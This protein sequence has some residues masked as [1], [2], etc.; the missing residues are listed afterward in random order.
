MI[1][2]RIP[3]DIRT[4]KEKI[5]FGLNVRQIVSS[6][7]ALGICVPLYIFG[8][9][10]IPDD[11]LSWLI[12]IIAVPLVSI[13]FVKV[14]GLPA[15]KFALVFLK[16]ELLFPKVRKFTTSVAY[17]VWQNE[18]VKES[19]PKSNRERKKE[20]K[21]RKNAS[22][23]RAVLISEAEKN[24]FNNFDVDN[25]KL[26][27]VNSEPSGSNGNGKKPKKDTEKT[28]APKKKSSLQKKAE[29]IEVKMSQHCDY[30]PSPKEQ[31]VLKKWRKI[32]HSNRVA[33]MNSKKKAVGNKSTKISHRRRAKSLIP[34]ST[35]DTIPYI[36]DYDEGLFE[37]QP[38]KYS[39]MFKISDVNYSTAKDED[40]VLFFVKLGEFYN[41]F[42]D[43]THVQLVIDNRL[44]SREEQENKIFYQPRGDS[45][46]NHRAEYNKILK[47]Q[48]VA[49]KN[50]MAII[51]F[52][53][54][55]IDADTAIEAILRFHKIQ[56]EVIDGLK[57][58]G[59]TATLMTTEERLSYYHDKFRKGR[60]GDFSID[61]DSVIKRGMS[62]KDYIAPSF[63]N[64]D[65]KHFIVEDDYYR[66]LYLTNLPASLAD[67]FLYELY[68]NDFPVTVSLSIQPVAQDKAL[69]MVNRKLTGIKHNK[70]EAEKR[71]SRAGYSQESIQHSIKDA[72]V[73][74]E[75]LLEDML[76]NNQK[77]FFVTITLMV[78]GNTLEELNDNT[79]ILESKARQRTVQLNVL[80]TQQEEG[81]K[82]TLPFGYAPVDVK[83]DCA[84]TTESTAI[85]MPFSAQE[86]FQ[87]G[88]YYY[89]LNQISRNLVI[90]DRTAM[91]TPSGFVLGS[92]GSGKSFATKR[93]ILNIL[94]NSAD[95]GV[96]VIDPENEYGDFGRAFNGTVI[97]LSAN[98][99][100]KINPMD[101]SEDYGLD[102]D[103]DPDNTPIATK[104]DKALSKKS[105]YILSL[106]ESMM[107]RGDTGDSATSITPQQMTIADRCV[108]KCYAKY[109]AIGEYS[110]A[111]QAEKNLPP[112]VPFDKNNIPTFVD[113][114]DELDKEKPG[115]EDARLLA[116]GIEFYTRGNMD[117]FAHK[118]NVDI[119]NRLV[120][121]NVRELG[122]K[123]QQV[124]LTIMFD[125][126]WNRMV[127][128]KNRGVRTYAYCDE[129][130]VMFKS[131][132]SAE[133]L[134]QLYK[135]GRK[136]G[137][138]VTGL[139]QNV[140]DLLRSEQARSM[141]GNSDFIMMLNQNS[142]DLA[143]LSHMLGISD[144][145]K[146]FVFGADAGSGLLFAENTIVP[147]VD[148]FPETS[149]L[150]KLMS[151]KFGEDMSDDDIKKQLS[152]ILNNTSQ[153]S[154]AKSA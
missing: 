133:F 14:N 125:F 129:I 111:R 63:F 121:F 56:N 134:R 33:A 37:I 97:K 117:V 19:S 78:H 92:S 130:H 115:S 62:S 23:E 100:V 18:A 141:I 137:L 68:N 113:F 75:T 138:C 81:M 98:S 45:L 4:Y 44:V 122:G 150:Y 101:M 82:V 74:A 142:E 21:R 110:S 8:R 3:K 77:M 73:K 116:E 12:I 120:V 105:Q 128:N 15:E 67:D 36:A 53:L 64:F 126:I 108:T 131:F 106:V 154:A 88:G 91:K 39:K 96:L 85:F 2:V 119:D 1:S 112:L 65:K 80:T 127:E 95:T 30:F 48:I 27:T 20:R 42:S 61:F 13:G 31:K 24:G 99:K 58:I 16:F 145:Q 9:N 104:I 46:D 84:L 87:P 147:F 25:A 72:L 107:M 124:A 51:K 35:Q 66:I 22:L 7:I 50:D 89:G 83:V 60:E 94:L 148:K 144:T 34:K 143:L 17:K 71:A 28:N 26:I 57:K 136:Y 135:R 5:M 149:Y 118:T 32:Q 52:V 109:L 76:D 40:Q 6:I 139:T 102:E 93:E 41:Y 153:S 90:V 152:E 49:G 69:K 54:V 79:K 132:Y 38:N 55:T 10:Y 86:L 29:L 103:D 59:S 114:Q 43:D 146:D 47:Q 140:E 70:M 151:T 11:Y 123:L